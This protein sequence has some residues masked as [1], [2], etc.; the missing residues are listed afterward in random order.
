MEGFIPC[1]FGKVLHG[2]INWAIATRRKYPMHRIV[3][4][5]VDFKSAFRRFHLNAT[6]VLK[7]CTDLPD[8]DLAIIAL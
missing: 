2:M 6:I 7:T 3:A 5:K 4:S 1:M 8:D